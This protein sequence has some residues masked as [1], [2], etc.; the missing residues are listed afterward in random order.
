MAAAKE[1]LQLPVIFTVGALFVILLFVMIIMLQA[2]F[3]RAA[4]Q[5]YNTKVVAPRNEVLLAS[6]A[7]QQQ[8]LHS[9]RWIDPEKGVVGIPVQRAMELVIQEG[10]DFEPADPQPHAQSPELDKTPPAQE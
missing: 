9:Y 4:R 7:E 5:E 3:Y 2:Y 1:D 8:Q 6:L 10:L